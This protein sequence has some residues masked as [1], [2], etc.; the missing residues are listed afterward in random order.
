M[1]KKTVPSKWDYAHK[2]RVDGTFKRYKVWLVAK[3]FMQSYYI[4]YL[5]TFAPIAKL[6][7]IPVL[8]ALVAHSDWEIQQYDK[9][10]D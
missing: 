2:Y 6:D 3:G 4:V 10:N 7:I 8:L 1:G 5:E 9:K